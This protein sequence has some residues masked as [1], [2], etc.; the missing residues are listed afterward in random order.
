MV[1]STQCAVSLFRHSRQ[2][3]D[4]AA[5][6]LGPGAVEGVVSNYS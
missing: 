4:D 6:A 1:I 3:L 2:L 5:G